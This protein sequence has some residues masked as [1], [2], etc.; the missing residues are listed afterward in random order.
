MSESIDASTADGAATPDAEPGDARDAAARRP[1]RGRPSRPREWRTGGA[2]VQ[3]WSWLL[4]GWAVV[5]LGAGVLV[6]TASTEFI[7]GVLG[8]WIGTVALWVSMLV[9]A[10]AA[11]R[12]SVPRGLFRFRPVDLLFG[13]V[14]GLILRAVAGWLSQAATGRS[15]WPSFP[16]ADGR[17][18]GGWWFEDLLVPT[19]VGPVVEELFFHA[20]LLVALFTAFRRLTELRPVAGAGAALVSTGLFLL[21]HQLTGSLAPTWDAAVSIGLVGLTGALLVLLTGRFWA[22]LLLH[23]V[24]NG[25]FVAL[26]LVGTLTGVGAGSVGL[27]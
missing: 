11:L 16:T 6:A 26:A 7:G 10:I 23:V 4:V 13:I 3:Q 20:L 2:S 15:V 14:L 8:G 9:P 17:L 22:A 5:A 27:S 1:R 18:P 19:V 21:L 24:F 12:L 25:S